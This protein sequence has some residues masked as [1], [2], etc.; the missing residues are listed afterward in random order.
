MVIEGLI[1]LICHLVIK[2]I[3][4]PLQALI[5]GR[6]VNICDVKFNIL[7]NNWNDGVKDKKFPSIT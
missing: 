6:L 3:R 2:A 1:P 7:N 4:N 5:K